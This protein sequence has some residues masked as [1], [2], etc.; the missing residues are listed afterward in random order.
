MIKGR[1]ALQDEVVEVVDPAASPTNGY[2]QVRLAL[3]SAVGWIR[4]GY[5]HSCPEGTD[6]HGR[7]SS[8]AKTGDRQV[9]KRELQSG[10]SRSKEIEE[11]VRQGSGGQLRAKRV[12]FIKGHFLGETG[13]RNGPKETLFHGTDDDAIES[14]IRTGFDDE[15]S[16]DGKFGPGIYFSPEAMTSYGYGQEIL[17]CEVA[18]GREDQRIIATQCCSSYDWQSLLRED[19][20]SVQCGVADFGQ[21]ERIVYHCTQ[22]KPV[23]QVQVEQ[24]R[25]KEEEGEIL[26]RWMLHRRSDDITST[27]LR[28]EPQDSRDFCI[29]GSALNGEVVEVLQPRLSQNGFVRVKLALAEQVGW[30]NRTYLHFCPEGTAG[31]GKT[32]AGS[33]GCSIKRTP[34]KPGSRRFNEVQELIKSSWC[35]PE[36]CSR[37]CGKEGRPPPPSGACLKAF[38]D[39]PKWEVEEVTFLEGQFLGQTGMVTGEKEVLFHGCKDDAI[40]LILENGFDLD[41]CSV[42]AF[43]QGN[44]FS[45]QAC[46]AFSYSY[47]KDGGIAGRYLLVCE[48]ALGSVQNRKVLCARDRSLDREK[49]FNQEGF[50]SA[51]HHVEGG[52]FRHEERIIY[53][54]TQC[55][56]V[57]LVKMKGESPATGI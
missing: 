31:R 41:Y 49:V 40:P 43:G 8:E 50:R 29:A 4:Q 35:V 28:S 55:K 12:W 14:I 42:G 26:P 54:N 6:D 37:R 2:V 20:R 9:E 47:D 56:P 38:E 48:V 39:T 51:V 32:A 17:L 44:Y 27:S 30:L 57:Y 1:S 11:F 23:Y 22:C 18:L 34:L 36:G 5:L 52:C 16:C 24:V 33:G 19:K 25:E 53:W 46:K 10:S 15:Y 45:P 13:M 3:S 7:L 21:E